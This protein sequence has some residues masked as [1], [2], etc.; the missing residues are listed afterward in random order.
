MAETVEKL[1]R[2]YH[3]GGISRR[4]FIMNGAVSTTMYGTWREGLQRPVT[5]RWRLTSCPGRE[6]L[7]RFRVQTRRPKHSLR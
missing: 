6:E 3:G 5:L 2:E 1:L 7:A 4:E